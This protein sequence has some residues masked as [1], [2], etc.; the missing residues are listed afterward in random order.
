MAQD[1]AA[2]IKLLAAAIETIPI[3][4]LGQ[5]LS[6]CSPLLMHP[7]REAV[8]VALWARRANGWI[9]I[10]CAL[11]IPICSGPAGSTWCGSS[12]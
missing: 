4:R 1:L 12:R 10:A 3:N 9:T 7:S 11:L 6:G 2:S 5:L 8:N